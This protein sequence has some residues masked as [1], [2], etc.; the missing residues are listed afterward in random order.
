MG[1]CL[2]HATNGMCCSTAMERV[3]DPEHAVCT[4]C[5]HSLHRGI[6]GSHNRLLDR[7]SASSPSCMMRPRLAVTE[8]PVRF[9]PYQPSHDDMSPSANMRLQDSPPRPTRQTDVALGLPARCVCPQPSTAA[10]ERGQ[11]ALYDRILPFQW[12][13]RSMVGGGEF[14]LS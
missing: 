13:A 14:M 11:A 3:F 7:S 9:G 12:L 6:L 1:I 8:T 4:L 2:R 5:T 10:L